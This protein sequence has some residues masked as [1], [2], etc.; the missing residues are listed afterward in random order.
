MAKTITKGEAVLKAIKRGPKRGLTAVEVSDRTGVGLATT[1]SY[2]NA[3]KAD[4][5][6][7]VVGKVE[8][9]KRGRPQLQYAAA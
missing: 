8:T 5:Y 1:R 7:K 9:G 6:I 3:L 2:L 4:G